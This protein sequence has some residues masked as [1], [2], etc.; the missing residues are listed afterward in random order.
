MN[1]GGSNAAGPC[2][3]LT[4]FIAAIFEDDARAEQGE[5]AVLSL[6]R[7]GILSVCGIALV[8]RSPAGPLSMVEAPDG[9]STEALRALLS[10]LSMAV[11]ALPSGGFGLLTGLGSWGDLVDFGV[12]PNFIQ[13]VANALLPGKAAVIAEIE[14]DWIT[15][16][17]K[18]MEEIGGLIM[19]TWRTDYEAE[20]RMQN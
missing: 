10:E 17:D 7:D 12:T 6:K 13:T 15:P 2:P 3:A 8:S 9:P 18:R 5:L 16:L 20:S 19:R 4:K 11:S 1:D 14:E